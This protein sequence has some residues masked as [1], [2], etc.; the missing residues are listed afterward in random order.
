MYVFGKW[1]EV[2]EPTQ[3]HSEHAEVQDWKLNPQ[4][5]LCD[6][7]ALATVRI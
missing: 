7:M 4:P 5:C 1:E 3:A 6:A 2:E